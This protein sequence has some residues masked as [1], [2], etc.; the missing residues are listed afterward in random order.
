MLPMGAFQEGCAG[1][2]TCDPAALQRFHFP[3][4]LNYI[5]DSNERRETTKYACFSF[6][7]SHHTRHL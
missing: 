3:V 6:I 4:R 7:Q 1:I 2:Q 5:L